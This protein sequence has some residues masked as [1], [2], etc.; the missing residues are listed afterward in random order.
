MKTSRIVGFVRGVRV[1]LEGFLHTRQ[2]A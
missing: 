2:A 1:A